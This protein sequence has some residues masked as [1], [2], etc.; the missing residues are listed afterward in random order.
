MS[1]TAKIYLNIK[2]KLNN[3]AKYKNA[4]DIIRYANIIPI[5]NPPEI[6]KNLALVCVITNEEP[7]TLSINK[8]HGEI[9]T[10]KPEIRTKAKLISSIF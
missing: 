2:K 8:I 9:P 1:I 5:S 10:I 4:T 6:L 3:D 7:K